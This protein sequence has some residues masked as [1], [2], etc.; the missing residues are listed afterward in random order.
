VVHMEA[1]AIFTPRLHVYGPLLIPYS[2][3][4]GRGEDSAQYSLS[5]LPSPD[6]PSFLSIRLVSR[7]SCAS[8][9]SGRFEHWIDTL[10]L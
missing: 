9:E 1:R 8:L 6:M 5:L 4:S 7:K 10:D 2:V 3:L